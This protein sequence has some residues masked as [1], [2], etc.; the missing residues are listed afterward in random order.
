MYPVVWWITT[1]ILFCVLEL[2]TA[3][4][5]FL[6]IG[7][8]AAVTAILAIFVDKPLVQFSTFAISSILLVALSRPWAR[9]LSGAAQRTAN[10]DALIGQSATVT[11]VDETHPFQ[12]YVKVGGELW[13]AESGDQS[14]LKMHGS[15]TV[16]SAKGNVLVVK[17]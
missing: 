1:A 4:F 15:V 16:V 2:F 5:F 8:G 17:V 13:K 6:W 12:G 3:S 10:V 9:R 14:G 11:K 7:A